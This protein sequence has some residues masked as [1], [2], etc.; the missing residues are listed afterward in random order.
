MR[1]TITAMTVAVILC[2]GLAGTAAAGKPAPTYDVQLT[3]DGCDFTMLASWVRAPVEQTAA[4][5]VLPTTRVGTSYG[6]DSHNSRGQFKNYGNNQVIRVHGFTST[7]S[8]LW[9]FDV[10]F[11]DSAGNVLYV[12]RTDAVEAFCD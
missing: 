2:L 1:R 12:W 4:A 11:W 7:T 10:F 9:Q 5:L 6:A 3:V 8:T